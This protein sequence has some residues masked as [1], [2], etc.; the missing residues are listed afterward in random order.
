MALAL[1]RLVLTLRIVKSHK[2]QPVMV[3]SIVQLWEEGATHHGEYS[4][5]MADAKIRQL[6]RKF[7]DSTILMTQ[8]KKKG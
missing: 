6:Q 5:E 1:G 8:E 3:Y 2:P 7:P 4:L